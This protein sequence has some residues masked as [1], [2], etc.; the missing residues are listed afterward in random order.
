M[1][2]RLL[3]VTLGLLLAAACS[4]DE[5]C[6]RGSMLESD[7]ALIVTESEHLSGWGNAN[8]EECH[9]FAV[10]HR[11]GCTPDVDLEA[12]RLIVEEEGRDSCA[13]CHGDNGVT[14]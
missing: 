1:V 9:S 7:G 11:L 8:C 2:N 14:P 3:P 13:T 10:I 5:L 12:L 6:P 4:Y